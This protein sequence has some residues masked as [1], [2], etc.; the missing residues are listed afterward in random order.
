M[1]KKTSVMKTINTD[2]ISCWPT[3]QCSLV[4]VTVI[5]GPDSSSPAAAAAGN[6]CLLLWAVEGLG[7]VMWRWL[8]VRG[9]I[10]VC[11]TTLIR[12]QT[13]VLDPWHFSPQSGNFE[14]RFQIRVS[15]VLLYNVWFWVGAIQYNDCRTCQSLEWL[16]PFNSHPQPKS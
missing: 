7:T 16:N 3:Q 13:S 11:S 4:I 2:G 14:V 6:Y 1:S 9:L 5:V 15:T 12:P 8:T 10:T